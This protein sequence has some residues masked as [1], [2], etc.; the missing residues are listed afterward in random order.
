[1]APSP[2]HP[3]PGKPKG[4]IVACIAA[5]V[6]VI[7]IG[8]I[9]LVNV[10][11]PMLSPKP[12]CIGTWYI[13]G[14]STYGI[15]NLDLKDHE[16]AENGYVLVLDEGGGGEL[17]L[18]TTGLGAIF[19]TVTW[20]EDEDRGTGARTATVCAGSGG[21]GFEF[22]LICSDPGD[23]RAPATLICNYKWADS[24]WPDYVFVLCR[25]KE[26]AKSAPWSRRDLPTRDDL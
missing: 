2:V 20:K 12:W 3:A 16:Y 21:S 7:A 6:A 11:M 23:E 9:L 22:T 4:R 8:G 19:D 13:A 25:D 15:N 24:E 18:G 17:R 26:T 14:A 5:A 10:L 1:P